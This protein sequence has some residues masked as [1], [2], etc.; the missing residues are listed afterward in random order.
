MQKAFRV[1]AVGRAVV[2]GMGRGRHY[3]SGWTRGRRSRLLAA[4]LTGAAHPGRRPAPCHPKSSA[5]ASVCWPRVGC[6]QQLNG[7]NPNYKWLCGLAAAGQWDLPGA[8]SPCCSDRAAHR[9]NARRHPRAASNGV[10]HAKRLGWPPNQRNN[11]N[12]HQSGKRRQQA[13]RLWVVEMHTPM[14]VGDCRLLLL[15]AS[16]ALSTSFFRLQKKAWRAC[17]PQPSAQG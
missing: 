8:R 9:E 12:A 7:H 5:R 4:V 3:S 13:A 17:V 1:R 14:K 11:G 6:V 2:L 16:S 15:R 10:I